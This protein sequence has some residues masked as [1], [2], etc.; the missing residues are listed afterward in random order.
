MD[1]MC[2][3]NAVQS[4]ENKMIRKHNSGP[5]L[6]GFTNCHQYKKMYSNSRLISCESGDSCF[7]YNDK[8]CRV[9]N[10]LKDTGEGKVTILCKSYRQVDNYFVDPL[11]S[12]DLGIWLVSDLGN[13]L[14]PVPLTE[15]RKKYA[16]LP[17]GVRG[18]FVAMP[19]LHDN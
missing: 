18:K 17:Y 3:Q 16:L 19:M 9:V 11:P 13:K 5:V 15:I 12:S 2:C 1:L 6:P 8:I 4:E 14:I 7:G 10:I